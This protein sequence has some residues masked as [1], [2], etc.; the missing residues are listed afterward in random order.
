MSPV[1]P[2]VRET[3]LHDGAAVSRSDMNMSESR[4]AALH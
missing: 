2:P 1:T 3:N 4:L